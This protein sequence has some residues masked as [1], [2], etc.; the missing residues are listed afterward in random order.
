MNQKVLSNVDVFVMLS[1]F[2]MVGLS[3]PVSAWLAAQLAQRVQQEVM[4]LL[5]FLPAALLVVVAFALPSRHGRPT[6]RSK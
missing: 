4:W 6:P 3:V 2:V 1:A 5:L